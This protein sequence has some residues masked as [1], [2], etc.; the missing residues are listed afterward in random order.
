LE[1][2]AKKLNIDIYP[3][4][5]EKDRTTKAKKLTNADKL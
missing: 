4:I 5:I 2:I 3:S 1:E